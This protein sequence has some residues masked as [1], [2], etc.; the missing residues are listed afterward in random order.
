MSATLRSRTPLRNGGTP[1]LW[2]ADPWL[3]RPK[4]GGELGARPDTELAV[5]PR[6]MR[7]DGA[8]R[9]EHRRCDLLVLATGRRLLGDRLLGGRQVV[10]RRDA[11]AYARQL[12]PRLV[13]PRPRLE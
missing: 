11:S 5:D 13:G 9:D 7:L 2:E 3:A 12:R 1:S 8:G 10:A 4:S 6:E